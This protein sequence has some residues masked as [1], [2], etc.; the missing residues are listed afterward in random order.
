MFAGTCPHTLDFV[1]N[2]YGQ[3]P[4]NVDSRHWFL[5]AVL[6]QMYRFESARNLHKYRLHLRSMDKRHWPA[7]VSR[8]QIPRRK[9][10]LGRILLYGTQTVNLSYSGHRLGHTD[11]LHLGRF[12][13]HVHRSH[14]GHTTSCQAQEAVENHPW[15]LASFNSPHHFSGSSLESVDKMHCLGTCLS[16]GP[17]MSEYGLG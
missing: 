7:G 4:A 13:V 16:T 1:G 12:C 11:H 10:V 6:C 15:C 3:H 9:R 14:D 2:H 17:L 8:V 5:E